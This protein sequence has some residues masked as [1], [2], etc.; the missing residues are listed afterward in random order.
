MKGLLEMWVEIREKR[1][2]LKQP[3]LRARGS[4]AAG[5]TGEE[6]VAV[7]PQLRVRP[8]SCNL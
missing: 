7:N 6:I 8:E 3:E 5:G 4:P 1:A 2:V